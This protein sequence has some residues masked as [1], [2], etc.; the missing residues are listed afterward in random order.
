MAQ[1]HPLLPIPSGPDPLRSLGDIAQL[2]GSFQ[3]FEQR[4]KAV[5]EQKIMQQVLSEVGGDPEKAAT[6]LSKR[7]L[8]GQSMGLRENAAKIRKAQQEEL[9]S[10]Y[11]RAEKGFKLS[12]SLL[13]PIVEL[14]DPAGQEREFQR[15]RPQLLEALPGFAKDIPPTLTAEPE[16]LSVAIRRGQSFAEAAAAHKQAADRLNELDQRGANQGERDRAFLD[17]LSGRLLKHVSGPDD[18]EPLLKGAESLYRTSPFVRQSLGALPPG[19]WDEKTRADLTARITTAPKPSGEPT[20]IEAALLKTTDPTRRKDL[21][22]LKRQLSEAGKAGEVPLGPETV[23]TIL[24]HP[25]V[26]GDITPTLRDGLLLPL[27]RA[28]F[29]FKAAARGLSATQKAQIERWRTDAISELN[30][31]RNDPTNSMAR[32]VPGT[33]DYTPEAKKSYDDE[34]ARIEA[35]YQVQIGT[36]PEASSVAPSRQQTPGGAERGELPRKQLGRVELRQLAPRAAKDVESLLADQ[37]DNRDYT[38]SDGTRWRKSGGKV[39]QIK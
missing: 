7:G 29:D 17:E 33:Q 24:T 38:L 10:R 31:Q 3:E 16:F 21:L 13:S 2:A 6:E 22:A 1:R 8:Y 32:R 37:P 26:W 11:D 36:A 25:S 5:K 15:V 28:G 14:K 20:N 23:Q 9:S 39:T 19:P 34:K 35:S 30:K 12:T 4:Q 18:L 27:A